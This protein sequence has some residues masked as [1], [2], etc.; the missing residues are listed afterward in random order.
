MNSLGSSRNRPGTWDKHED[1]AEDGIDYAY[2]TPNLLKPD[3][4][5]IQLSCD[6]YWPQKLP[7]PSEMPP[8]PL[9]YPSP[10]EASEPSS[11]LPTSLSSL[12]K[13]DNIVDTVLSMNMG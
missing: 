7:E 13:K 12:P 6:T 8:L 4:Q 5:D 10:S 1:C 3:N 9:S 2:S 11:S